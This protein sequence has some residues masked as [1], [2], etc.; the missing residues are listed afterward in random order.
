MFAS[1]D[2]EVPEL[3]A[4]SKK[5]HKFIRICDALILNDQNVPFSNILLG[6]PELTRLK[7]DLKYSTGNIDFT[8]FS[9]ELPMRMKKNSFNVSKINEIMDSGK[10]PAE[11][12]SVAYNTKATEITRA[13]KKPVVSARHSKNQSKPSN[14]KEVEPAVSIATETPAASNCAVKS[15]KIPKTKLMLSKYPDSRADYMA[16]IEKLR[17]KRLNETTIS[18]IFFDKE[19]CDKNPSIKQ[20]CMK[21]I[22]EF[23]D[24]FQNVTGKTHDKYAISAKIEGELLSG[25]QV[26]TTRTPAVEKAI[27]DKLD[28]EASDG[29][30]VFPDDHGIVPINY[31]PIMP[32]E[33]KDETGEVIAIVEGKMRLIGNCGIRLNKITQFAA[34]EIDNMADTLH[35]AAKASVHAYKMKFDI[36]NAFHQI[37]LS[38]EMWKYFG[39][40]HPTMGAMVYTRLCQGWCGSFGWTRNIFLHMFYK[41]RD[42]MFRFMDDGFLYHE[43]EEGFLEILRLF[44]STCRYYGLKLKGS[45]LKF[46]EEK[47]N[48]L[49]TVITN[50]QIA[51]NPHHQLKT[52]KMT[53]K[54]IKTASDLRKFLG[55]CVSL[56]RHLNRSTDIFKHLRKEAGK[57]GKTLINWTDKENFL[58]KEFLK[59][60]RALTELTELT[61]FDRSKPAFILVDTSDDGTGAILYQKNENGEN[62][63]V[64]FYSR[65]RL[66]SERKYVASSCVLETAG[67]TGCVNFWRRYLEDS[68][69]VTTIFTDSRSLEAVAARF[70]NNQIPSDVRLI[71]KFFSDL[72]GLKLRVKYIP[73]KS[74]QITGV[75]AMSRNKNMTPCGTTCEICKLA[76]IPANLPTA[77]VNQISDFCGKLKEKYKFQKDEICGINYIENFE[78]FDKIENYENSGSPDYYEN[79]QEFDSNYLIAPVRNGPESKFS[80]DELLNCKW[81]L[82]DAQHKV[83]HIK[84]AIRIIHKGEKIPPR[85]PRVESLI[86]KKK[87]FIENGVL[88]Y[89]RWLGSDEFKVI[90]IHCSIINSV[91]ATLHREY[92][93][94]SVTQMCNIFN[95]HFECENSKTFI[96]AYLKKCTKCILLRKNNT[97]KEQVTRKIPI[98]TKIGEQIFV[99]EIHRTDRHGKNIRIMMATEGLSRFAITKTYDKVLTGTDF[100]SFMCS[101]RAMLAPLHGTDI[102]IICR[103]DAAAPHTSKDTLAKLKRFGITV[104][105]YQ[106]SSL[107]K[108]IIPEHDARIGTFGKY[109]NVALNNPD[110]HTD[111]AVL[112]ATI[113]YNRS[114]GNLNW[115][116][117]EIFTK[118]RLG[119]QSEVALSN[120]ELRNRIDKCRQKSRQALDREKDRKKKKKLLKFKPWQDIYLN[121]PEVLEKLRSEYELIKNGDIIKLHLNY[122]KN[123]VDRLYVIKSIDW[124]RNRFD[125]QKLNRPAGK[126]FS[127]TFEAIDV[128]HSDY[129]RAIGEQSLKKQ[130]LLKL[131]A[132]QDYGYDVHEMDH[133]NDL[134]SKPD[135][136]Y[137]SGI[138][139]PGPVTPGPATPLLNNFEQTLQ[140]ISEETFDPYMASTPYVHQHF[141]PSVPQNWE[142]THISSPEVTP[143][144]SP[145]SSFHSL[146]DSDLYDGGD[147][148]INAPQVSVYEENLNYATRNAVPA[149]VKNETENTGDSKCIKVPD[150]AVK[151]DSK[152]KTSSRRTCTRDTPPKLRSSSNQQKKVEYYKKKG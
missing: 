125:A 31:I 24:V 50:G 109:L 78:K 145:D 26:S 149:K 48:F 66:D 122:N 94:K 74:I 4:R 47:M 120:E 137:D 95:R 101:A 106:S 142:E 13:S 21:I 22:N 117:A 28:M 64:E 118:R 119:D 67:L 143:E 126:T 54:D 33:K 39:I 138:F 65:K 35:K 15:L 136:Q 56:S 70:A 141:S 6:E 83:K 34:M 124:A 51:P 81:F 147:T 79:R 144:T 19:F 37:P 86:F 73:G 103:C 87:A 44:L 61:P 36:S 127:F 11:F 10:I 93:C 40:Y 77:F 105:I 58:E 38:K 5:S 20:K 131:F 18:D 8:E 121:C 90:P 49:G 1:F 92:G 107:S 32:I 57:E 23:S 25:R 30:L 2:L 69:L 63:V 9:M 88:K 114:L 29:V 110:M 55:M 113:Q 80:L 115:S 60:K 150:V 102:K 146:N 128:V 85:H 16:H 53:I 52:T 43:T 82:R 75:D 46:F 59:A 98:P 72:Q 134:A 62:N 96:D 14:K 84:Q 42:R 68:E 7:I 129:I 89:N 12:V 116:P 97:R 17:E 140:P 99:D 111:Q 135:I 27:I 133:I 91:I 45:K 151:T 112:W 130:R 100:I 71:N 123:D 3:S 76:A 139:T 41:F 108:N 104:E 132:L 148:V 152:A